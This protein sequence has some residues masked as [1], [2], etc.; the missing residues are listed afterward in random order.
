MEKTFVEAADYELQMPRNHHGI[1]RTPLQ[2][3]CTP[4]RQRTRQQS[5]PRE[6]PMGTVMIR[7]PTTG[8][9]ISTGIVADRDDFASSSVFFARSH[10]P[11]CGV[12][13][14]WFATDAWVEEPSPDP[15]S[16][17]A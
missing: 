2:L 9:D 3:T 5:S 12:V 4:Q 16:K 1:L 8:R 10:C 11:I 15:H 14:E 17:A 7:C 13:H 6:A